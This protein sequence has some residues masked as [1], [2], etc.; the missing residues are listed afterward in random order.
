MATRRAWVLNLD[1]EQELAN[2][3][4]YQPSLATPGLSEHVAAAAARLLHPQDVLLT[5]GTSL[6]QADTFQGMAW[7]PTPRALGRL[8]SAGVMLPQAPSLA[9]LSAANHRAFCFE[10]GF[11]SPAAKLCRSVEEVDH[12]L[13]TARP[14][15]STWLLKRVYGFSGRGLRR[16]FQRTL[17]A[18]TRRFCERSLRRDGSIVLEP[19]REREADFATHGMLAADGPLRLGT[20]LRQ[21]CNAA[22]RFEGVRPLRAAELSALETQTLITTAVDVGRA[23]QLCGYFGP[24]GVDSFRYRDPTGGS[25]LRACVEVN[26]RYSMG[27]ALG[28]AR[29]QRQ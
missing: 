21:L 3:A 5:E 11:Q 26:A 6:A 12:V 9:V 7:C 2:P 28:M 23:L 1:A 25:A 10:H 13:R 19:W 15:Q 4:G 16:V 29:S 27:W 14:D 22:G 8:A 20:P 24:F 17:D 18:N